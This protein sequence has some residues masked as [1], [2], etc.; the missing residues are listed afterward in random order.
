MATRGVAMRDI[1]RYFGPVL[2]A[3]V[4]T[5]AF[6]ACLYRG[7]ITSEFLRRYTA[8]H[9]VEIC[10]VGL[11]AIGLMYLLS[12]AWNLFRQF[13]S[14]HL[15]QLPK[16]SLAHSGHEQAEHL[17]TALR[18]QPLVGDTYLGRRFVNALETVERRQATDGLDEELKYLS[19][20]DASRAHEGYALVRII[21]WATPMLGFLGTVMGITLALG[22]LSPEMLVNSPNEAMEGLLAGLSI[23]FDTTALALILSMVLMF[24]QFLCHQAESNLLAAVDRQ[25]QEDLGRRFT[26]SSRPTDPHVRTIEQMSKCVIQSAEDLV[27]RQSEVWQSAMHAALDRWTGLVD[28]TSDKLNRSLSDVLRQST[29]DHSAKLV[30]AEVDASRRAG[31][32]WHQIQESV[33][34]NARVLRQQQSEM[35]R[36]SELLQRIVDGTSQITNLESSLNHNLQALAG[37]KNF[38]DTV[39]SLSAAIHL[40][41]SRLGR[42]VPKDARV[43]L[44]PSRETRGRAA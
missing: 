1:W 32:Y 7:V 39:M 29:L 17:L 11:F 8:G 23:A 30:Q 14:M 42:P 5:A 20:I 33:I 15:V 37:A 36:Q 31:E 27:R 34:E 21:I 24:A 44:E 13:A 3:V 26:P 4:L 28:S 40:L 18:K 9:P 6:Y 12:R 43:E 2:C 10:E 38:E 22:D 41:N 19:D 35:A 16:P 25:V